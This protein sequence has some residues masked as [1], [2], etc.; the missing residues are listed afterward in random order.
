MVN[1]QQGAK[2]RVG[3]N[4]AHIQQARINVLLNSLN[5]KNLEVRNTSEKS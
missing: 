2:R 5:S 1:S 4:Q 3:Y